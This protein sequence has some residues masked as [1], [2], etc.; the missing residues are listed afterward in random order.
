MESRVRKIVFL[1]G[2]RAE[3]GKMK[4]LIQKIEK[5]KNFD[6]YLFITGMHMLAKYGLTFR[7]ILKSNHNVKLYYFKNQTNETKMD[8][9][10][11][12]TILGFSNFIN[13]VKPDMVIIHG[14]RVE[15][16]AGAIV[17]SL[18]NTLV[19][20]IEG[21]EV[22]GT[23][24]E[25]I[26]HSITKLSHIHFVANTEAKKRVLQM[27]EEKDSI[28]VIGSPDIDIMVSKGLPSI[29]EVKKRYKIEYDKY[30]IMI[31]HPVVTNIKDLKNNI[32]TVLEALVESGKNYV[33]IYPNNDEGSSIIIDAF[34]VLKGNKKFIIFPSVRFE[35]FL[36]LL[37]NS[38]FIIGNSSIG[39]RGAN[40][41]GVASINIGTRQ[42]NRNRYKS[43]GI[44]NVSE[45]KKEILDKIKTVN[46]IK[47]KPNY[48]FGEG[49][50]CDKFFNI[51]N[52]KK[53][54]DIPHQK[55]FIDIDNY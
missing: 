10:L 40:I 23:I 27:G 37:K 8:I 41:Y 49:N 20:H 11:S 21:G 14:D 19:S 44:I 39:V 51:L 15:A 22:S 9:T 50:S 31:Y 42:N 17:G 52:N 2:T 35:C 38:E 3:Y 34:N 46:T 33:V 1:T 45:D 43:A 36:T 16:F 29:E 25:L 5:S 7:E 18:N 6:V 24:D 53:I 12:N 54:W 48:Y 32:N 28:F 30:S 26:R 55:I 13:K 4:S 47:I